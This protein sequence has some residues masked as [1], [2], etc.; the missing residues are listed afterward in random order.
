M[1]III[2]LSAEEAAAREKWLEQSETHVDNTDS[3]DVKWARLA[4][5]AHSAALRIS[6]E[7]DYRKTLD[8]F[9][10]EAPPALK[11][12]GVDLYYSG[13]F[14]DKDPRIGAVPYRYTMTGKLR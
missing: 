3:Y 13:E 2:E 6:L 11:C 10:G 1:R 9:A 12:D 4:D 7:G 14:F 5:A 8:L